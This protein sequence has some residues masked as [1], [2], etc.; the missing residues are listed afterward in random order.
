[1]P[2]CSCERSLGVIKSRGKVAVSNNDNWHGGELLSQLKT[3][4][5][6]SLIKVYKGILSESIGVERNETIPI[7]NT[8]L[9]LYKIIL[10]INPS[11][12]K[13]IL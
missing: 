8:L 6:N 3:C 1:M 10:A 12:T 4:W 7:H 11:V 9:T 5:Y 2:T 13:I